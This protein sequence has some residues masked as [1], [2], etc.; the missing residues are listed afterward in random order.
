M[1]STLA[2][3][4]ASMGALLL[5]RTGQLTPFKWVSVD[6]LAPYNVCF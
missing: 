2:L 1:Y 6:V 4:L 5:N 3:D